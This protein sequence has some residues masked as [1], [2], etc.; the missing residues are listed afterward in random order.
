VTARRRSGT[1]TSRSEGRPLRRQGEATRAKLLDAALPA[2]GEK[3]FHAA[4]VD[5]VVRVAGV[6]HGTF[7]LYFANKEELFRAL[8]ERCADEA[9][10]LAAALPP[11]SDDEEGRA[12]L[13]AW[14][15]D[16]LDFY[17]RH[18]VVIRA[19][20]ENQVVDRSLARLGAKSFERIA[21]TVHT[22]MTG[23]GDMSHG[24]A[25]RATAL[26]A[27]VERF[28]YTVTSRDLGWTDDQVLDTLAILVH[29]GWFRG[30]A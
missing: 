12:V 23:S 16:Y 30:A 9:A 28:A 19:W 17:R 8:A 22:S 14:L 15:A 3:G 10:D 5:D 4:R 29:R 20:A 26:L 1:K 7:Y 6:S 2:L 25:L 18:G 24:V 21:T 27:L 11:I 13:R